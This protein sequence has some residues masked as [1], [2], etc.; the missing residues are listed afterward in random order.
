[1]EQNINWVNALLK[2]SEGIQ[3]LPLCV[4]DVLDATPQPKGAFCE[5]PQIIQKCFM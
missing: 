1:M 4:H 5:G 2:G 3:Y